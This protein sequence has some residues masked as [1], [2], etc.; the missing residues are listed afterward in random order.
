MMILVRDTTNHL[1]QLLQDTRDALSSM[2]KYVVDYQQGQSDPIQQRLMD[3][4][5]VDI[6]D[7][8]EEL[9]ARGQTITRR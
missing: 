2:R 6:H 8:S 5:L 9:R 7:L 1:E 4:Y 3:S